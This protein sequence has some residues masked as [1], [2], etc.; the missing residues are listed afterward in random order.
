MPTRE[1]ILRNCLQRDPQKRFHSEGEFLRA[2]E[3]LLEYV[4]EMG[5]SEAEQT[6]KLVSGLDEVAIKVLPGMEIGNFLL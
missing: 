2:Y 4:R 6:V 1:R 3:I 5:R